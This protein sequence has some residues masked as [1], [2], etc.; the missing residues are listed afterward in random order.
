MLL[1]R[2]INILPTGV[3]SWV[4]NM[5]CMQNNTSSRDAEL[6]GTVSATHAVLAKSFSE[7]EDISH[8]P[9]F[10]EAVVFKCKERGPCSM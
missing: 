9:S 8:R 5:L 1:S 10:A 4:R 7:N 2:K 3:W 6:N